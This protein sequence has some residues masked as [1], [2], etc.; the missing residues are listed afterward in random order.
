M[1]NKT[2]PTSN[3]NET[4]SGISFF[5]IFDLDEIQHLQ[6]IFAEANSIAS[7]IT[8]PDGSPITKPSNF[9]HLCENIVRNTK[10]GLKNCKLSDAL[11][12][13]SDYS[14]PIVQKCLGCG[15]WDA[16]TSI[17]V[18]GKHIANWL[19]GQVRNKEVDNQA[20]LNYADEIGANR[21]DFLK[22]LGDVPIMPVEK[23]NK[24]AKMLFV[25]A[26]ELS[27]KAYYNFEL[28]KQILEKENTS[29]LLK[30]TK[31]RFQTLLDLAPDAFFQGDAKGNFIEVNQSA[32]ELTLFS[33]EEL[34]TMNMKDLFSPE[35]EN[36]NPL[37]Y[38]LL[39]KGETIKSEREIIR[40][41]KSSRIV[42]MNSKM[43]PDRSFQSFFRDIT[44]R[45]K[46]ESLLKENVNKYR[47]LVQ[48]SPDA[49]VIYSNN[50][51]I[52]VNDAC[53]HLLAV[54]CE[55]ELIGKPVLQF[56]H[57][58]YR[59]FVTERMKLAMKGNVLPFAEEKVIRLNGSEIDVEIKA[60][61]ITLGN[62]TAVQLIIRDV[63]EQK[64]NEAFL[65][66]K[67]RELADII[68]FLPDATLGI[69]KNKCVIIWN[70]A[71]E[72]M[73]G[74][75]ADEMIGK[76][77]YAYTIPFYGEKRSQLMDLVFKD[78]DK[79]KNLYPEVKRNDKN[80]TAEF[81]CNAL[82]N[83]KGAWISA[84][85]SPLHDASGNIIG[86]I[87]SLRDITEI[88][89]AE[90]NLIEKEHFIKS[91]AE[92]SPDIIYLYDV[93]T[94]RNIYTNR[95]ISKLLGYSSDEITDEYAGFFEKLIHPEDLKQFNEFYNNIDNWKDDCVYNFE[96]RILD[97]SGNYRW[98]KGSEKEFQ[99]REGKVVSLI[100]TVRDITEKKLIDNS[101]KE[102]EEKF[103]AVSEY[104][105]NSI[106]IINELGKIIWTN[107]AMVQ[108]GGYSKE[109][110][111]AADTFAAFLAP[112][113]LEFVVNNF[114]DFIR[115]ETYIHHYEFY[116]IRA[117]G[118]KRLC[119]KYMSHFKDCNGELN[120][121]ISINDITER[122]KTEAA[123]KESEDKYRT[124]IEYSN[125]LIW[126]L[127]I[128]GKFLFPK[129]K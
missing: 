62:D 124:M 96:Y 103:R 23:F 77:D 85:V 91:I 44:E 63:T 82:Y 6:D 121:V 98:F 61:P 38:D 86:A 3:I 68:D 22:A 107:E 122:R 46:D 47:D 36:S 37:R 123:L 65:S 90:I 53:L 75:T 28:K 113:S 104:S 97:K 25:F 71:I 74:I 21:N 88:K 105:F 27:E 117:D 16:G 54:S 33:R 29:G 114:K 4:F 1:E 89:K 108:M 95:S 30:K 10:K 99:R 128:E 126:T 20:M 102:S 94:N 67:Q 11:I 84:K 43:M 59:D 34:L 57:P 14:G 127:D 58:D 101:F 17:T 81:F 79:I 129:F 24:I 35:I 9:T 112:E 125:D 41:D 45:K 92:N 55:E 66:A 31:E 5:D 40:K 76:G 72:E 87:E 106:C 73:T 51:V 64:Q 50:K 93:K 120:L 110:I 15:L 2:E 118:E 19:I 26:N 60:I 83:N 116:I 56:V 39:E 13:K 80:I 69:D 100:G 12:G 119:E 70:K 109:E 111:Y 42:E 7:I 8:Y 52:F 115:G 32:V 49:I 78:N 18:G 48:N